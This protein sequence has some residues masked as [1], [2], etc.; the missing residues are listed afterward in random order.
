MSFS[1]SVLTEGAVLAP[2]TPFYKGP[3]SNLVSMLWITPDCWLPRWLRHSLKHR[4]YS[5]E[6]C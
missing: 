5:T 3:N 1:T 4:I 2:L 6:T